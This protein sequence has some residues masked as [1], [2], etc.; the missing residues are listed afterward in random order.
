MNDVPSSHVLALV[1]RWSRYLP[2]EDVL[3]LTIDDVLVTEDVGDSWVMLRPDFRRRVVAPANLLAD[4]V[5]FVE[6]RSGAT[7]PL[8]H[9]DARIFRDDDGEPFLA[10]RIE[11]V[12]LERLAT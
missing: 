10:D 1:L 3:G 9:C 4:T 7:S 6:S 2:L 11:R 8:R 12:L 5:T